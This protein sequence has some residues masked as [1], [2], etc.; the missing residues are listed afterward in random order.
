MA[1]FFNVSPSQRLLVAC[2]G[3][4]NIKYSDYYMKL[5]P[6]FKKPTIDKFLV[7]SNIVKPNVRVGDYN[8]N[9]LDVVSV[10]N[11]DIIHRPYVGSGGKDLRMHTLESV[12][13]LCTDDGG[14]EIHFEKD[15]KSTFELHIKRANEN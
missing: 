3:F 5:T 14:R 10:E 2:Y 11:S 4:P 7:Y 13:I 8:T 9:L 15:A 12:T 6:N 1:N